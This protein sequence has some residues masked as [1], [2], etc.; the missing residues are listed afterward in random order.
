MEESMLIFLALA[1]FSLG[2]VERNGKRC[3]VQLIARRA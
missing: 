2:K 3:A 1:T